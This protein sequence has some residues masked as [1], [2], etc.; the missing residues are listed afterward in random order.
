MILMLLA[1]LILCVSMSESV[2]QPSFQICPT[3][4][5]AGRLLLK[6]RGM[7]EGV[8]E[9]TKIKNEKNLEKISATK[10]I[11]EKEGPTRSLMAN[12]WHEFW[13]QKNVSPEDRW[14]QCYFLQFSIMFTSLVAGLIW[15]WQNNWITVYP[16]PILLWCLFYKWIEYSLRIDNRPGGKDYIIRLGKRGKVIEELKKRYI[17]RLGKRGNKIEELNK[18]YITRLGKRGNTIEELNKKYITRVGKRGRKIEDNEEKLKTLLKKENVIRFGKAEEKI[19][20]N[21]TK[22]RTLLKKL[23][24]RMGWMKK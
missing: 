9:T 11:A 19:E 10:E 1:L 3:C 20:D 4:N 5:M 7:R 17:T 12:M 21:E 18:R 2:S 16:T 22:L 23:G 24:T 14:R 6:Y 13:P 15:G 8:W